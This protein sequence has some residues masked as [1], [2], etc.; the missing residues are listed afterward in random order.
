MGAAIDE[1]EVEDHAQLALGAIDKCIELAVVDRRI[2]RRRLTKDTGKHVLRH[3]R[4][5]PLA[6]PPGLELR[7]SAGADGDHALDAGAAGAVRTR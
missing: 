5:Q 3:P 7:S 4:G 2:G 6:A 1:V